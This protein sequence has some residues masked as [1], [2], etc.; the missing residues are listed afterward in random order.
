[1]I[2]PP[3]TIFKKLFCVNRFWIQFFIFNT[4][5]LSCWFYVIVIVS[6]DWLRRG[7]FFPWGKNRLESSKIR[8]FRC[9]LQISHPLCNYFRQR[10]RKHPL[11]QKVVKNSKKLVKLQLPKKLVNLL[12]LI[13][14]VWKTWTRVQVFFKFEENNRSF[15]KKCLPSIADPLWHFFY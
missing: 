5:R 9:W 4:E 1:M 8:P 11:L 2:C 15:V 14:I 12:T 10:N 13:L 6:A 3:I 7:I